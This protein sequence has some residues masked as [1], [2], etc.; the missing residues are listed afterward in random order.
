MIPEAIN[1]EDKLNRFS[2]HW[3][4]KVIAQMNNEK[5]RLPGHFG[6]ALVE[7]INLCPI[8]GLVKNTLKP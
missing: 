7:W 2:D 3:S 1:L 8:L 5:Y 6:P 4:P